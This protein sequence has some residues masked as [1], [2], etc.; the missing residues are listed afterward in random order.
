MT[1]PALP[2]IF[3]EE[4]LTFSIHIAGKWYITETVVF[5]S[6]RSNKDDNIHK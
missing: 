3:N 2:Q 5:I 4:E 6:Y 1:F